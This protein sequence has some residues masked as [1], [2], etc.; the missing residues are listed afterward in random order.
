MI[1][2]S[3]FASGVAADKAAA[4]TSKSIDFFIGI[5]LIRVPGAPRYRFFRGVFAAEHGATWT[6]SSGFT[7]APFAYNDQ[8]RCGAVDRPVEPTY[9]TTSPFLTVAPS[10]AAN[11]DMCR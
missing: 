1:S 3:V 5:Q 11:F 4:E 10:V 8:C 6:Q 2:F 9:P 7:G